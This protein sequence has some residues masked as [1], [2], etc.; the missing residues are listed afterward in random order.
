MI[1]LVSDGN[2]RDHMWSA[3]FGDLFQQVSIEESDVIEIELADLHWVDPIPVISLGCELL[4]FLSTESLR[5]FS[6]VFD[7][8]DKLHNSGDIVDT[9]KK[10]ELLLPLRFL[11]GHGFFSELSRYQKTIRFKLRDD[12]G[13][14]LVVGLND[15]L[16]LSY[17]GGSLHTLLR[18]ASIQQ[19]K[20]ASVC[21]PFQFFRAAEL[22]KENL[23]GVVEG[24]IESAKTSLRLFGGTEH[25]QRD[26]LIYRMR[27][28]LFELLENVHRHAYEGNH[29]YCGV[30]ARIR[31]PRRRQASRIPEAMTI[32]HERDHCPISPGGDEKELP[33]IEVYVGDTG[34]GL[35]NRENLKGWLENLYRERQR[36]KDWKP[37]ILQKLSAQARQAKEEMKERTRQAV[38]VLEKITGN[39]RPQ[40]LAQVGTI[41]SLKEFLFRDS[42]STSNRDSIE[43]TPA[44]GL[45]HLGDLL[46]SN[47]IESST[48]FVR[49]YTG[50][51]WFGGTVPWSHEGVGTVVDSDKRSHAKGTY[52]HFALD[53]I[54]QRPPYDS[55]YW[56]E[57]QEN[58]RTQI[59]SALE[60]NDGVVLE[61]WETANFPKISS[62]SVWGQLKGVGAEN[63]YE[64]DYRVYRDKLAEN[65]EIKP[66]PLSWHAFVRPPRSMG[67]KLLQRIL[68]R[69]FFENKEGVGRRRTNVRNAVFAD[70]A[71]SSAID[72]YS[73]LAAGGIDP[74]G[75]DPH[76]LEGVRIMFVAQDWALS[77]LE[78]LDGIWSP[79]SLKAVSAFFFPTTYEVQETQLPIGHIARI[80]RDW[81]SN[82]FWETL[83]SKD[84]HTSPYMHEYIRWDRTDPDGKGLVPNEV[85][86]YLDLSQA[87][88][89]QRCFEA[90]RRSLRRAMWLVASNDVANVV[91]DELIDALVG[92]SFRPKDGRSDTLVSN[93]GR[94]DGN[95]VGSVFLGGGTRKHFLTSRVDVH[96]R[97]YLHLFLHW[98]SEKPEAVDGVPNIFAM[99]WSP[100]L[101]GPATRFPRGQLLCR[102]GSTAYAIREAGAVLNL[103]RWQAP[104]SEDKAFQTSIYYQSPQEMYKHWEAF[105]LLRAGHWRVGRRHDFLTV[106]LGRI[107]ELDSLDGGLSLRWLNEQIRLTKEKYQRRIFVFIY[108]AHRTTDLLVRSVMGM[109]NTE[110]DEVEIFPFKLT[111][112]STASPTS[113]HAL[114]IERIQRYI[115]DRKLA[116]PGRYEGVSVLFFNDRAVSGKLSREIGE[117]AEA[118]NY[119]PALHDKKTVRP[120]SRHEEF[121]SVEFQAIALLDRTGLP[122]S[123]YSRGQFCGEELDEESIAVGPAKS[124]WR[125]DVPS[126]GFELDCPLCH[127]LSEAQSYEAVV[128][129]GYR[130]RVADWIRAWHATDM[131]SSWDKDEQMGLP[132]KGLASPYEG[133]FGHFVMPSS[134]A[135][136]P[137]AVKPFR[138]VRRTSSS[139]AAAAVEISRATINRDYPLQRAR[140]EH[141]SPEHKTRPPFD[142]ETRIELVVSYLLCMQNDMTYQHK[143]DAYRLLVDLV[144]AE[145]VSS[146]Y[147]A[148]ACLLCFNAPPTIAVQIVKSLVDRLKESVRD[149]DARLD[150]LP[151]HTDA[152][153]I[154]GVLRYRAQKAKGLFEEMRTLTYS[155]HFFCFSAGELGETLLG[156]LRK[157]FLVIGYRKGHAA[158]LAN[159]DDLS[160]RE[161]YLSVSSIKSSITVIHGR[162][163]FQKGL[164]KCLGELDTIQSSILSFS[165][166]TASSILNCERDATEWRLTAEGA[167]LD[168]VVSRI[169]RELICFKNEDSNFDIRAQVRDW[170]REAAVEWQKK[171]KEGNEDAG[172]T[173]RGLFDVY[174]MPL[175]PGADVKDGE[176]VYADG[177]IKSAIIDYI[178]NIGHCK[179]ERIPHPEYPDETVNGSIEL[180]LSHQC[181]TVSIK[182]AI[183][184]GSDI[185]KVRHRESPWLKEFETLSPEIVFSEKV[186]EGGREIWLT[187]LCLPTLSYLVEEKIHG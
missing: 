33:F 6:L 95:F 134:D 171:K 31:E 181:L 103:V 13:E 168:T 185:S 35:I 63:L 74:S 80:L 3:T 113:V 94:V 159:R 58:S 142:G 84:R 27:V 40:E 182:S 132:A 11:A 165:S 102:Q 118:T 136:E 97:A 166:N 143:L 22:A 110:L 186:Q 175:E 18:N 60:Q 23:D 123:R 24:L 48:N 85:C 157:L 53:I 179:G 141:V 44:T 71:P 89:Y 161:L 180:Y 98:S 137:I 46:T 140:N 108:L 184:P 114:T 76:A 131:H 149:K 55:E 72:F 91:A 183:K 125:W 155:R 26:Y 56:I 101:E 100:R 29:G 147:T 7:L 178:S 65:I 115:T 83:S 116:A 138:L 145:N 59:I 21:I 156:S 30:Y 117:I 93:G 170:I 111:S 5:K 128:E 126:I 160:L 41:E 14:E 150:M 38:Q 107:V 153:L 99:N 151:K 164:G 133:E 148:I 162:N 127:A 139:V 36:Q 25:S 104:D 52:Y 78:Y 20:Y 96:F 19:Y 47:K 34:S 54:E 42:L 8:G 75:G 39:G 4:D 92:P 17:G 87:L 122:F 57:L 66:D 62:T 79:L 88:S 105:N 82:I 120:L 28:M 32:S 90:A 69:L 135:S 1:K 187:K 129:P 61:D 154:Y 173:V 169:E 119:A 15:E 43:F 77:G 146:N 70:M 144:W 176:A 68:E 67:K 86:G 112:A 51:E 174:V 9:I 177:T 12:L 37:E 106:N 64:L 124:M 172:E 16:P 152:E 2:F 10:Y 49:I 109:E 158:V 81:D 50:G 45:K 121:S 167:K 130:P 163:F 73:L